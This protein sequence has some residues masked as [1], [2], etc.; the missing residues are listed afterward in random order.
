M[1]ILRGY[2]DEVRFVV[3]AIITLRESIRDPSS[4]VIHSF[5]YG[6]HNGGEHVNFDAS[7]VNA[8][9]G[10]TRRITLVTDSMAMLTGTGVPNIRTLMYAVDNTVFTTQMVELFS[11]T[12]GVCRDEVHNLLEAYD[13]TQDG[14]L[15]GLRRVR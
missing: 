14:D 8:L 5:A 10:V 12:D 11:L 13:E 3:R 1:D 9:G 7:G 15:I 6:T 4:L 2:S